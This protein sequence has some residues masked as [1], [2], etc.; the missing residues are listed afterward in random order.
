MSDK[1]KFTS[2]KFKNY[3]AFKDFIIHL[4]NFNVLVGPNNSGKSTILGALRI[5]SEGIRKA[6]SRKPVL[7]KSSKGLTYGYNLKLDNIPVSTENVFTNYDASEPATITF[8]ISNGNELILYFPEKGICYLFCNTKKRNVTNPTSFKKEYNVSIGFVPVLGPVEHHEPLYQ[9]EA[10]RLALFTH[11][12]SRNFRNIWYHYP[13]N[14]SEFQELIK[15]TW[16]GMEIEPPEIDFSHVKPR[17]HI[18]CPEDRYP[19]EIFWAGFGFQVWCQMLTFIVKNNNSSLFI[20]DEPDIYLHSDLQCQLVNILENIDS[21]ILIATHST[22]IISEV[23]TI[24]LLGI[25]KKFKHSKRIKNISQ[26]QNIFSL[27]GSNLNPT[28]TQLAKSRRVIFVEGKDFR[29]ISQF[30]RI[31]N[32]LS[33]AN[34]SDFAVIPAKGFNPQKIINFLE[35]M[36]LTLGL[37]LLSGVVF[38]RDYRSDIEVKEIIDLLS[39]YNDFSFIHDRKEIENFLLKPDII[40][41]AIDAKIKDIYSRNQ[42]TIDFNDDVKEIILGITNE[43]K[44]DIMGQYLS[45]RKLFEKQVS[46]HIDDATLNTKIMNELESNWEDFDNRMKLVPGKEVLSKL[47]SYILNK[48]SLSLTPSLIIRSFSKSDIPEGIKRIIENIEKL[49]KKTIK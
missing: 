39:K 7:L 34:R 21:D 20:I 30:A 9:K 27:L 35:G 43:M 31:L 11:S 22:E 10:A 44:N 4:R 48:Y 29:I 17:L 18:F 5:L 2:I 19:R 42:R 28:I 33:I 24:N 16:P 26:L 1:D 41:K 12:A 38:D 46:P 47:F 6:R 8:K 36:E 23:D 14:F 15:K 40:K 32:K 37:P 45:K 3:K 13:E 25:N 49:E